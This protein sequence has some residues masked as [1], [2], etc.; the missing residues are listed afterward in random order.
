MRIYEE[1]VNAM[2]ALAGTGFTWLF[3]AWDTA[4]IVLIC[5]MALD[6]MTGLT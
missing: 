4:L 2:I 5:F 1:R 6:Y 3:G